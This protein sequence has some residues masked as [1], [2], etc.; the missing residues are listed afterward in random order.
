MLFLDLLQQPR[1]VLDLVSDDRAVLNRWFA[2]IERP[3]RNGD[4]LI[5]IALE[6]CFCWRLLPLLRF[7][8]QLR[9]GKNPF[10]R[11]LASGVAPG[12]VQQFGLPRGPV[13]LREDLR[14][15][16]AMFHVD[17]RHRSQIPHGGLR[18][19]ASFADLLLHRFRQRVHQRQAA[20]D[21]TRATVETARQF[22]DRA[23]VLFFQLRQ[24]PALFERGFRLA[25]A[26][27]GMNQQQGFGFG[28]CVQNESLD[29]IAPQ[30]LER[31]D[32]LVSIDHQIL[33]SACNYDDRRLLACFSQRRQQEP[34]SRRMADPETLQAAVQLMKLQRLRH[35][36][37]YARVADWSFPELRSCCSEL[38]WDQWD[39]PVTG[40]SSTF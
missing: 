17:A 34:E 29:R 2:A 24:Q 31:G 13:V 25:V 15:A 35:G 23:A 18:G 4:D 16:L 40:L 11:L 10:A 21:P 39:S 1:G 12:V 22:F 33:L 9:L 32:A 19:N 36:F 6:R 14:H 26:A 7:Q 20:R 37:Q 3:P 30:L 27:Q 28:R 38:V 8:K 5:E